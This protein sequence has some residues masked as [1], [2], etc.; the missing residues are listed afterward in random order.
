MASIVAKISLLPNNHIAGTI[1]RM[2]QLNDGD[3]V[4]LGATPLGK[5]PDERNG[6]FDT[7]TIEQEHARLVFEDPMVSL[8][9]GT[10]SRKL[11]LTAFLVSNLC[12]Q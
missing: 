9:D 6:F 4:V 3:S 5:K 7:G 2:F 1:S 12:T 10:P 8:S 11:E